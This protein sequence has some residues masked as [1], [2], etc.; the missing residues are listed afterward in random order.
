M[1]KTRTT[2]IQYVTFEDV[3]TE[4]DLLEIRSRLEVLKIKTNCLQ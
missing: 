1:K 3:P 4:A 2:S